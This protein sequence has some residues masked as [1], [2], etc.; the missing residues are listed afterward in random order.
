[1][2][3]ARIGTSLA[4]IGAR[5]PAS[6]PRHGIPMD[7]IDI[8][9]PLMGG[10]ALTLGLIYV[11]L[12]FRARDQPALLM[13]GVAA[14]A[15]AALAI[16][17]LLLM[18]AQTPEEF[19][20]IL[21]QAQ[22][23]V[24]LALVSLVGFVRLHFQAGR[25]WLGFTGC[26]LRL[27]SLVPGLI[28]GGSLRF[29]SVTELQQLELWGGAVLAIPVAEP[30]PWLL[31]AMGSELLV[32]LFFA[33]VIV[34]V[35][36]RT[37]DRLKRRRVAL[38]CGSMIGFIGL[39]A[40]WA[41]L[42]A[43][44]VLHAPLMLNLPFLGVLLVMSHELGGDV[45]RAGWLGR[46][47]EQS[48]SDLRGSEQK[49]QLTA[50]AVGLGTW[51]WDADS[52]EP[53]FTGAGRTMLGLDAAGRAD[54]DA[55]R[56][57][58]H[59]D[60]RRNLLR[61]R[62]AAL[63]GTGKFECEY[64]I[65]RADGSLR[66][67]SATGRVENDASGKA[68]GMHGVV[69]DVTERRQAEERFRLVVESSP[70]A[71]LM[72]D[73]SGFIAFANAQTEVVFGYETK[74][75][76]GQKVEVLLPAWC[77]DHGHLP[78]FLAASK[79]RSVANDQKVLGLHRDG[80]KLPM[81]IMLNH[82]LVADGQ[83]VLA[84]VTD[85]TERLQNEQEIALQR[86]E[87]AHL[88]RISLLG[89]MSGSLAHELNQPLTAVLSNAQA[90]LRFLDRDTPELGEVRDSLVQIVEND[91]R[92]GEVIRR[93]RA[94]L[95][96]EQVSYESLQ[97]NDVVHDVLRLIKSDLLNRNVVTQLELDEDIPSIRGDRVQL[98]Q[99]LLN[100]VINACDAMEHRSTGRVL[101]LRTLSAPHSMIDVLVSDAG[102]GVPPQDLERIFAP[103]VTS[104]SHGMGLGLAVC[105][106]IIQAHHGMLWAT[107]N[108]SSGATLHVR[109]PEYSATSDQPDE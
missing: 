24:L 68:S 84:S 89:E 11:L 108:A 36:R 5:L 94:M 45:I 104:K 46:Q 107:N 91:K 52:S 60:D 35:R 16:F 57:R 38:V 33:D 30:N 15:I 20:N 53:A 76:I 17:E 82:I 3:L 2:A 101:T 86:E 70:A 63:H 34:A 72:V 6:P 81:E 61:A 74:Q 71:M 50:D 18:R 69:I 58:I 64:R 28:P 73:D 106:T 8:V 67:M 41:S 23:P 83:F 19:S 54:H 80:R 40:A 10:V 31:L 13:F 47:L 48:E 95:R 96:K 29:R 14:G 27:G 98:Q 25:A 39:A 62:E 102:R 42:V 1:M 92:A 32:I 66:W 105:R 21:R 97:I 78:F 49:L 26:A 77:A 65:T 12:W 44:G 59:P 51:T 55:V 37:S 109:L 22:L 75:L 7:W 56:L 4:A 79:A 85:L 103:F 90:A 9:W 88:S 100:L 93:L 99:V 43:L 87:L